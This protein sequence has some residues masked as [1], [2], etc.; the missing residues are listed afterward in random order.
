[1]PPWK[2][3]IN[4]FLSYQLASWIALFYPAAVD[5]SMY[6]ALKDQFEDRTPGT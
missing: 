1:M 3:R 4:G 2:K 6:W 5:K